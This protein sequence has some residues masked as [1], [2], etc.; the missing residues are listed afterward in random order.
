MI[1]AGVPTRRDA[2]KRGPLGSE[3]SKACQ[4][5]TTASHNVKKFGRPAAADHSS[6]AS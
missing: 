5:S 4:E 3:L 6:C 1:S 2:I